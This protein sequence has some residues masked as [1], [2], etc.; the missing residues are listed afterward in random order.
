MLIL[1]EEWQSHPKIRNAVYLA[2]SPSVKHFWF[3]ML[4]AS[5]NGNTD[6]IIEV[7]QIPDVAQSCG[8]D[9]ATA[10]KYLTALLT[11]G[12]R[13]KPQPLFHDAE[14]LAKCDSCKDELR[15]AGHRT[16]PAD[17]VVHDFLKHNPGSRDKTP[18][19]RLRQA[20]KNDLNRKSKGIKVDAFARDQG[21]CRFCGVRPVEGGEGPT[22]LDYDHQDPDP[23]LLNFGNTIDNVGVTCRGC[24]QRKGQRTAKEAGMRILAPG[25]TREDVRAGTAV[26]VESY[27]EARPASQ[28]A[29]SS[30]V[31]AGSGGGRSRRGAG[32]GAGRGR[33]GAGGPSATRS[34]SRGGPSSS[35]AGVHRPE[36]LPP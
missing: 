31:G 7:F 16:G 17:L 19:G 2:G 9:A 14:S 29:P 5:A 34:R 24:N 32:S 26:Y 25:T 10:D 28:P 15:K 8:I 6:G 22:A 30:G 3:E 12:T 21:L 4:S 20:R 13:D 36:S 33:V 11:S 18:L 23:T 27:D 1:K 35:S